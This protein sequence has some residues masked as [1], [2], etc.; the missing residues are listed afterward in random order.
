MIHDQLI[1]VQGLDALARQ[2]SAQPAPQSKGENTNPDANHEKS[3]DE[4]VDREKASQVGR[5]RSQKHGKR[6]STGRQRSQRRLQ[7]QFVDKRAD[8]SR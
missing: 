8:K 2:E 1:G 7:H 6:A 5:E 3:R 4:S